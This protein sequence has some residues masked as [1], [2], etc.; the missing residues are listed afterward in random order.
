MLFQSTLRPVVLGALVLALAATVQAQEL[1]SNFDQLRVLV[2]PG[3]VI[4]IRD[5][6]GQNVGGR[7]V[8][9]SPD[10]LRLLVNGSTREFNASDVDV[11]TA[12]RHGNTANGAKYGLATGAGVGTL[13][14]FLAFDHC[15]NQ[16]VPYLLTGALVYGGIGAGLGAGFSAMSTSQRVIFARPA[17]QHARMTIA[18]VVDRTHAGAMLNVRW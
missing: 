16:C 9:L 4:H 8:D 17:A 15:N 12:A 11:V 5:N 2:K 13:I 10:A 18:P 1:A 7:L 3:D 6:N 14:M